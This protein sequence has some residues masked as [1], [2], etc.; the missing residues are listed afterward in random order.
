MVEV[1]EYILTGGDQEGRE[2]GRERLEV[3]GEGKPK[4][5]SSHLGIHNLRYFS[6]CKVRAEEVLYDGGGEKKNVGRMEGEMMGDK[7]QSVSIKFEG[8]EDL[9]GMKRVYSTKKIKH[10]FLDSLLER[11]H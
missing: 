3:K 11:M 2:R 10:H 1:G 6:S 9:R 7:M 5:A 8:K 4:R